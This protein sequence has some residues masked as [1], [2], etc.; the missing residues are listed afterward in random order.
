MSDVDDPKHQQF[1]DEELR[2]IVDE[3]ARGERIVAAHAHGKE[4]IL[5]AL[6]AGCGTIEHGTYLDEEV[7][8]TMVAQEAVLVPTRFVIERLT[9]HAKEAGVPDYTYDKFVVVERQHAKALRLAVKKGV[10]IALGTDIW[11][12]DPESANPWGANARELLHLVN[13]GMTPLRAIEAATAMGPL[14]LG[15]QAPRSGRL[16]AGF[17]ADVLA[18]AKN[19]LSDIEILMSPENIVQIWKAGRRMKG[20]LESS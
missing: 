10:R 1:S 2:A 9:K 19:P 17:D 14:T 15:P 18:L 20:R 11:M 3:A 4:G 13:A 6:R 5:A 7:A 16:H 8:E 12:S